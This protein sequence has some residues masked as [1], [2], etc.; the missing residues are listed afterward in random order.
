MRRF[1]FGLGLGAGV[2][3]LVYVWATRRQEPAWPVDLGEPIEIPLRPSAPPGELELDRW[4][5]VEKSPEEA[6][7]VGPEP[8][9]GESNGD[10]S[11]A[12]G[13][14]S[15]L[16]AYCVRCRTQRPMLDPQAAKTEGGRAAMRGVCPVCGTSLF[17]F[18]SKS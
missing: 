2:G 9:E 10:A 1:I 18:V 13:G 16:E 17:R 3:W 12:S 7:P 5:P 15:V 14:Q 6:G 11:E 8:R 4:E